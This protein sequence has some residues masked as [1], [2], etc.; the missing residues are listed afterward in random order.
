MK[1]TTLV[2]MAAGM[3]SRYGGIKQLDAFGSEGEVIMDY[4]IFD[5]IKAGFST[6]VIIIREDIKE[7]F[8]EIVG[9]RLEEKAGVP[10]Y[11]AFQDPND[12]PAGFSYPEGRTKP[13]GTGQAVLAARKFVNEPFLVIN[14]DDFYGREPYKK[15]HDFLQGVDLNDGKEHFCLAGYKLGNTLSDHGS[16]AR[17]ICEVDAEGKLVSIEETFS[18]EKSGEAVTGENG[19][20][21]NVELHLSDVASM[22]MMGFTPGIFKALETDF[23]VFLSELSKGNPLKAEFLLP[24]VVGDMIKRGE[25]DMQVLDTDARWFGVTYKEDKPEVKASIE[26]L[27]KEGVYKE[28]LWSK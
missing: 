21:K 5:A 26:K 22:N 25:A 24:K 20:G 28:P 15:M 8:M 12:I 27:V 2:V 4:S 19:E 10:V 18:I 3:G 17:G 11:Y 13:W 9:K 14:A 1:E 23:T 16:V 6:V 7:D